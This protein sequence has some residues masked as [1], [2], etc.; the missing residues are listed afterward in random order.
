MSHFFT[1]NAYSLFIAPTLA[2]IFFSC[3]SS[4]Y[5][6]A[7]SLLVSSILPPLLPAILFGFAFARASLSDPAVEIHFSIIE[8]HPPQQTTFD[9]T[10][11]KTHTRPPNHTCEH[12]N[13]NNN[14]PEHAYTART[15][16]P[17][18]ICPVLQSPEETRQ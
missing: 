17:F 5:H 4:G 14:E 7:R 1:K 6:C 9:T 12:T 11:R 18:I 16:L 8:T 13:N 15:N 3:F 2:H 10:K